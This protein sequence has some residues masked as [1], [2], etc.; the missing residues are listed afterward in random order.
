MTGYIV[1]KRRKNSPDWEP[2]VSGNTPVTGT[3]AH[4]DD[5]DENGEYE[6]R[7]KPVNAAGVGEPSEPT[8][9]TKIRPK[10]G[11]NY[12]HVFFN[13]STYSCRSNCSI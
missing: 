7:I 1:E 11:N 13:F 12:F 3:Q 5:L 9:M 4:I 8:P 6:F 10:R 2:A